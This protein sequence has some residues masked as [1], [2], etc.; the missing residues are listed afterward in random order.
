MVAEVCCVCIVSLLD[1]VEAEVWMGFCAEDVRMS[2]TDFIYWFS[3]IA[4]LLECKCKYGHRI[5]KGFVSTK[6]RGIGLN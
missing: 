3:R 6:Q 1:P 2:F 4:K 5:F